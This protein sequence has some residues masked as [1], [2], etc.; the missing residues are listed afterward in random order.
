[1]EKVFLKI[2][3]ALFFFTTLFLG[4]GA[5]AVCP[6][7]TICIDNPLEADTIEELIENIIDFIVVIAIALAPLMALVG[8]FYILT[9]GGEPKRVQTG[10]DI[11][12]YT[13]VGLLIVF[14]AKGIINAIRFELGG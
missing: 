12:L 9:S 7:G 3:V 11:I 2:F 10:K 5:S 1:M 13:F 6:G 4:S 8:A 14:L